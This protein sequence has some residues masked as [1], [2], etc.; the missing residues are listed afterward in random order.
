MSAAWELRSPGTPFFGSELGRPACTSWG[1]RAA[2]LHAA[3][4]QPAA[5]SAL[6][7]RWARRLVPERPEPAPEH[8]AE[9]VGRLLGRGL[10]GFWRI[11]RV[12]PAGMPDVDVQQLDLLDQKQD[13]SARGPD[14]VPP[15]VQQTVPPGPQ[16]LQLLFVQPLRGLSLPLPS[17]RTTP[18]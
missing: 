16:S 8:R 13:G 9:L 6:V 18:A 2:S 14:L 3:D 10:G 7:G 5:L 11:L 4:P 1:R 12:E 15:V 17:S